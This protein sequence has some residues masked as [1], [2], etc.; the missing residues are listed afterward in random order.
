MNRT[1]IIV[2]DAQ[3]A[4][5]FFVEPD[6]APRNRVKLVERMSLANPDM[7]AARRG[8][9]GS[10]KTERVSNRQAGDV[11]PIEGRRQQHRL[12]LERRFGREITRQAGE[13][14]RAWNEGTLMLIAEPRLLGLVRGHLREAL[15]PALTLK[16]L[17][18]NYVQL[19][20][21]ELRDQ[22][23]LNNIHAP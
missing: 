16:E 4:R 1:C 12:E 15:S 10:V 6:D 23:D 14:T 8:G 13:L 18:K 3:H 9:A 5:F 20:A 21:S 11:H 19:S 7:E 2:A 17:A 22:L